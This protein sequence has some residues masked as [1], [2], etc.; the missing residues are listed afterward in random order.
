M[1][2][3]EKAKFGHTRVELLPPECFAT[4]SPW[5]GKFLWSGVAGQSRRLVCSS[6]AFTDCVKNL[7]QRCGQVSIVGLPIVRRRRVVED[8]SDAFHCDALFGTG[9]VCNS[10]CAKQPEKEACVRRLFHHYR[11]PR[12]VLASPQWT[13]RVFEDAPA[14]LTQVVD[15]AEFVLQYRR[16]QQLAKDLLVDADSGMP[17]LFRSDER[18][19]VYEFLA[20]EVSFGSGVLRPMQLQGLSFD[21]DVAASKLRISRIAVENLQ[22]GDEGAIVHLRG[23]RVHARGHGKGTIVGARFALK[24]ECMY[25]RL[26]TLPYEI[27]H[28]RKVWHVLRVY[29]RAAMATAAVETICETVCSD[30]RYIERRNTVGRTLGTS[31]LVAATRLRF[32]GFRGNLADAS[33][34]YS[35]LCNHFETTD[36]AQFH[37][38]R[39]RK[40]RVSGRQVLSEKYAHG[41]SCALSHI[42]AAAWERRF[43]P[44]WFSD[45]SGFLAP[46]RGSARGA[47]SSDTFPANVWEELLPM[48]RSAGI[49]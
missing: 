29:H 22:K 13:P 25:R 7:Q 21:T 37:F 12:G 2:E 46:M 9:S 47:A 24:D 15:E 30:L 44:S 27:V 38:Q 5:L 8:A 10:L 26:M 40:D 18:V 16:L 23:M 19:H 17:T 20:L 41:D 49:R 31:A 6:A 34:I 1:T 4:S 45:P 42:R 35:A 39:R 33:G 36:P 32:A 11:Q 43:R 48:F 14:E 28:V 3:Q